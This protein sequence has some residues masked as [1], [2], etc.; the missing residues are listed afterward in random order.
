MHSWIQQKITCAWDGFIS[1]Q[2]NDSACKSSLHSIIKTFPKNGMSDDK[3]ETKCDSRKL[4]DK[5]KHKSDWKE[6]ERVSAT[7][8]LGKNSYHF[9][10]IDHVL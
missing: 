6:V 7:C 2:M 4:L 5:L 10:R 9:D 8:G 1:L 3:H